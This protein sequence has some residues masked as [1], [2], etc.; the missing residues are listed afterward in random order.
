[1][2]NVDSTTPLKR[3]TVCNEWFPATPEYFHRDKSQKDGLYYN[4]KLCA[5]ARSLAWSQANPERNR[6]R[7]KE[8]YSQPQN[9]EREREYRR[10]RR[11]IPEVRERQREQKREWRA[12]N[13]D[14]K[15]EANRQWAL[16]N[17][18]KQRAAVRRWGK[19]HPDK[20]LA[21]R[22]NRM[23]RIR[24]SGTFTAEELATIRTAQTDKRGL[25]HCWWCGKP[26]EGTPE[27][28][29]KVAVL[30]GGPNVAGNLCYSCADCNRRK[31]AKDMGEWAG[32]LL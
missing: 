14:K 17:P 23:K 2:S 11:T 16:A 24:E 5:R 9:Q 28:D 27:I 20:R 12:A 21:S 3:C 26:I 31:G 15:R 8:W 4:C 25:L 29:H 32:R 6:Q 18:D 22:H 30:K 1:M 7:S 13:R 10:E 19:E